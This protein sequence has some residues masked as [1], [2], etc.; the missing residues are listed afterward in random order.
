MTAETLREKLKTGETVLMDGAMGTEILRRDVAT[1]LPLWSAEALFSSPEVIQKI[2]EDYIEAGAEII[3]TNT[4]STTERVLSKKGVGGKAREATVRACQL[5][6]QSRKATESE[7]KVAIAGSVAPLEDCYSPELTPPDSELKKE[8]GDFALYLKAGGVDF[9]LIETMITIRETLA[10]CEAA[11]SV[12]LP[13]AVSFCCN[14]KAELLG[15]ETLPEAVKAIEPYDPIFI[16]VNCVS[17]DIA[18]KTVKV[19][20][21]LTTRPIAAY[22]QGDGE[23]DDDQGWKFTHTGSQQQYL[24]AAK[25][26]LG[27]GAQIVG[28]CCGTTPE[29]I[30]KLVTNR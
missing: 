17:T 5:A 12:G 14:E 28:G 23:P 6:V 4:F 27:T 11:K 2:H 25:K 30:Q 29:D 1:T 19:L 16:G 24:L 26:W 18:T 21:K 8:H 9:I 15:G 22:A 10:A 13:I 20:K 7:D 3:I